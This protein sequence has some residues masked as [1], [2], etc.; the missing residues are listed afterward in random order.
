[1]IGDALDVDIIGAQSI[2]MDQVFY[3][4]EKNV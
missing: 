1:M 4:P 2:G 3:N